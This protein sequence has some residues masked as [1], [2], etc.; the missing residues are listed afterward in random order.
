VTPLSGL[1][2]S[3]LPGWPDDDHAAALT[4]FRRSAARLIAAPP[5]DAWTPAARAAL[6]LP[7]A[8]DADTA[9]RCFE[10]WFVPTPVDPTPAA[11]PFLTGYYEP[12]PDGARVASERFRVPL[13]ARPADLIDVTAANRPS[14]LPAELTAARLSDGG[15]T[16]YHTRAEIE[17]GALD[18]RGLELAYVADPVDAFLIHVQGSCRLRLADSAVLRLGYA[19]KAGHPYTSIGRLLVER[20]V[21]RREAMTGAVLVAWLRDHP[22]EGRALMRENRSYIFFRE[23]T[24]LDPALGPVG[25]AGGQLTAGR[26]L[27]VDHAVHAYGTP[28]WLDAELPLGPGGGMTPFRRLMLAEDTGSAI[29]GPARGDIFIGSG[30][31]AGDIAG[32][33]RHEARRFVTLVPNPNRI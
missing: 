24:G 31:A 27:A 17:D 5:S 32:R 29:V 28:V 3:D 4:V 10:T 7:E 14:G 12:E 22:A 9:R 2:F 1:A 11:P 30:R 19:G 33:I 26:S 21:I 18:G 15:P 16:P 6:A 23:L 25:A 13:H 20:G 8:V